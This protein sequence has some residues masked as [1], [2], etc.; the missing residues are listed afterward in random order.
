M[1]VCNPSCSSCSNICSLMQ[2]GLEFMGMQ[3]SGWAH[4]QEWNGGKRM[5]GAEVAGGASIDAAANLQIAPTSS[6]FLLIASRAA[7]GVLTS[8]TCRV[9]C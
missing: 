6:A 2:N 9:Q 7:L 4:S 1:A 5:A 8:G 3:L